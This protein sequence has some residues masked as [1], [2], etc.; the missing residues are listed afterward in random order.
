M[1]LDKKKIILTG[2]ASG[3]GK[4][5]LEKLMTYDVQI[6]A[7]DL[8][9]DKIQAVPGKVFPVKCDVSKPENIDSLM[10]TAVKEMGG[11]DIFL[12][13]AGFAYYERI[14]KA[15]WQHIEKIYH[16]NVISP[17][18]SLEKMMELNKGR[19][20]LVVMTASTMGL[21]ALPGYSLYSSTKAALNSFAYAYRMEKGDLGRLAVLNP[22][23]TKTNF[24]GA[25]GKQVPEVKPTQKPETVARALIRGIK[26][27]RKLIFPTYLFTY[28]R[29]ATMFIMLPMDLY[30][31]MYA[32]VLKRWVVKVG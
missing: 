1:K 24:F 26:W 17:I 2:A 9:P 18:Y 6:V 8:A 29:Y 12:A 3:I 25:A 11:V 4:A 14:E 27:N 15:D 19:E 16:T 10:K 23:A 20:Y 21:Q 31:R 7:A 13:N 28:F 22:I 32:I 5:I 30:A